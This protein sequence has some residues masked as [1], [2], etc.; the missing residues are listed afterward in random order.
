MKTLEEIIRKALQNGITV[1]IEPH[2]LYTQTYMIT[3]SK[4][5]RFQSRIITYAGVPKAV[6]EG[7]E[8]RT[9]MDALHRLLMAPYA[10]IVKEWE[11]GHDEKN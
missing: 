8:I 4:G 10:D 9:F 2:D 1:K 5:E 6:M 7:V 3:L 11:V